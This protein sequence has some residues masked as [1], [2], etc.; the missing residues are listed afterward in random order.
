MAIR[1]RQRLGVHLHVVQPAHQAAIGQAVAANTEHVGIDVTDDDLAGFAHMRMQQRGDVAG[2][3]CQIQHPVAAFDA[4]GG[5][6]IAL[7][8][9]VDTER[10]Q[11]VHQ[12]VL[13]RD[14]AEDFADQLALVL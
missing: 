1:E 8:D 9:A 14:R 7:P 4:G 5:D 12:I 6:E 10:H 13:A 11:V 3:S 2:A